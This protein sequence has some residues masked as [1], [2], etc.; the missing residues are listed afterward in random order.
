[1]KAGARVR[2][3]ASLASVEPQADGRMLLRLKGILEIEG[4]TKPALVAEL[5]CMLI[6]NGGRS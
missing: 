4:E 1:V 3:R 2:M 6:G 5:L